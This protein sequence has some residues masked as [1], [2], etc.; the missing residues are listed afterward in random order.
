MQRPTEFPEG[1]T[2]WELPLPLFP[3]VDGVMPQM[4]RLR[5]IGQIHHATGIEKFSCGGR[6]LQM[7]EKSLMASPRLQARHLGG[8]NIEDIAPTSERSRTASRLMM[9]LQ[10]GDG[11]SFPGE[12]GCCGETGDAGPDHDHRIFS[13]GAML[14]SM[15]GGC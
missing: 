5:S 10:Q 11:N 13:H 12:Q 3:P 8:A 14:T 4:D 1:F 7:A 2:A 9:G 15:G 6:Q